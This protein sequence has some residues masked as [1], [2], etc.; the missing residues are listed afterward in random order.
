MAD[1]AGDPRAIRV[2]ISSTFRDMQDE[3]EE[4]V[5][6][7]FPGLRHLCE[8][9]GVGW[10]EVDL[11]WGVTDEQKADGAVLPVCLAEIELSRP[12]FI[13][14]LGER[15]GWVPDEIPGSLVE[16]HGW[17][18]SAAGRS[19]TE[20]EILHGVLN[21]PEMEG[22][23]YFYLRDPSW[24]DALPVD[25]RAEYVDAE[26][27]AREKLALLKGRIR[28]SGF[29]VRDGYTSARELGDLVRA[30]LTALV[31]A[32]Y[33]EAAAPSP[34]D[35]ELAA[36]DG[37]AASRFG[38]YVGRAAYDAALDAHVAGDGP[39]LVVTGP[40]G[41]GKS[42]L[43]ANWSRAS[44]RIRA[45][46]VIVHHVGA[47]SDSTD[48]AAMARRLMGELQRRLAIP[49]EV[50]GGDLDAPALRAELAR[51]LHLAAA[52]GRVVI[53]IDGVDQLDDRDAA[54]DLTWLPE[55]LPV[56]VRVVAS[57]LPGRSLTEA[58]RRGWATLPVEPLDDGER[59][60]L[61]TAFLHRWSKQLSPA[62]ADRIA[63][64]PQC[65]NPLY[66]RA[67]LD[68][69]RQHGDHF[70]LG[71]VIDH[72][73][74]AVAVDDLYELI[75]ARYE[76]DYERDRPGLVRDAC[77]LLWAA[78][79]GLS[80]AELVE[81]L[82]TADSPLP[83]AHWSPLFLAAEQSFVTRAGLLGFF[84]NYLRQAVADRYLPAARDQ[85]AAH[86][87][88][89]AFFTSRPVGLRKA[90]ELPWQLRQ[91][92]QWDELAGT[93]ADPALF[94]LAYRTD[95]ADLRAH[96]AAAEAHG[97]R[98]VDA[99]GP[100]VD[101]PAAHAE[102]AWLV[103]R[104]LSDGGYPTE[105][106][107]LH[108]F[109]VS[110]A[111]Q[112]GDQPRLQGALGN[113]GAALMDQDR[114]T[115]A[116]AVFTDQEALCRALGDDNGLQRAL[117]SLGAV[118]RALRDGDGALALMA[119]EERLCRE[120]GDLAGLQASIGNQGG[121][122]RD[123]GDLDGAMAKFVEQER[124]SRQVGDPILVH[125]A[126]GAQAAVLSDRG[127]LAEALV[128][129]EEQ[130]R[131]CRELGDLAG[132]HVTLGNQAVALFQYGRLD[133]AL[134]LTREAA[135]IC[136]RLGNHSGLVQAMLLDASI[137]QGT[138]DLDGAGGVLRDVEQRCRDQGDLAN[139]AMAL[140]S[141]ATILRQRGDLDGALAMH[142]E[143]EHLYRQ[144]DSPSGVLTSLG[145]QALVR[146]LRGDLD[147]A[148]G[149]YDEQERMAREMGDR[150]S[151]ATALGN[152]AT[153]LITRNDLHGAMTALQEQERL[154]RELGL[155]PGLQTCVG[156][157]GLI[158][159][160]WGD[161]AG[162]AQRYAEQEQLC[163]QIG[164][165]ASLQ[166]CLGNQGVLAMEQGDRT[167]AARLLGEQA[168]LCR[169]LGLWPALHKNLGIQV[170]LRSEEGDVDALIALYDEHAGVCRQLGDDAGLATDLANGAT[171]RMNRGDLGGAIPLFEEAE[172][173]GRRT[174]NQAGLQLGLGG[175]GLALVYQGRLQDGLAALEEQERVCR[176]IGDVNGLQSSVGN[177]AIARR[178]MGDL[179]G[180]VALLA[181][182]EQLCRQSGNGG[183]LVIALANRGEVLGD[184]PGRQAEAIG[185]LEE[186]QR[187]ATQMGM[188]PMAEQIQ[189]LIDK[190]RGSS[191]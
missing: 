55:T 62:V 129:F 74:T 161:T 77:S 8:Q 169:E 76:R 175:R 179:D 71:A 113:L 43:L 147:G 133:R 153:L 54:R 136:T 10:G 151:L 126:L 188:A 150:P 63:A 122:L 146:Q 181:Q 79:R 72:Y 84:H 12:Y 21:D 35:R 27:E 7:V 170:M 22:H 167:G 92:E 20:L 46:A 44:S 121:V 78:R 1:D 105:A 66:L 166:T 101:D 109:L 29:P 156:N 24:I 98:M 157:I 53:V 189:P 87:R 120:L 89:A 137:R 162:A 82:G 48:W 81:L 115:E 70:T 140:G 65:G 17:L 116:A 41:S 52:R 187:L 178:G 40:S 69:L 132:L 134:Q 96:W 50:P 144:V 104:M 174:G 73:L 112:D 171:L 49:E 36:H 131:L 9:R 32:R 95:L 88:L 75:L 127:Q 128:R 123:R 118:R 47:T 111:R 31:E 33:P 164:D 67:L 14:L 93:L 60:Q 142:V 42:A 23:A 149:L 102:E 19:V 114:W 18:A 148:A 37:Y 26:P 13:G 38:I 68:E 176:A 80:E 103:A 99:Y 165:R 2:F 119:E 51:W 110:R 56:A 173:V 106:L 64:A 125:R 191:R 177:Q 168:A 85:R 155:L 108:E 182:Q 83:H 160:E 145:N 141:E 139:L 3:R 117:G 124:L 25:Q 45:D 61:I 163:R 28:A 5:K 154:C 135:A 190:I 16:Q 94:D 91:A 158:L 59:H 138:G 58:Q 15:Y 183:G 130:E 57:A 97:H 39:P 186:A 185:L 6:R 184:M 11:R 152:R 30:D 100:V 90:D 159:Q 107:A 34:L 86:E 143:E 4:L 172:A 180:A